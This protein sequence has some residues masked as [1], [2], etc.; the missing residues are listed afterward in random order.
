M[1]SSCD[2]ANETRNKRRRKCIVFLPCRQK[3]TVIRIY[4]DEVQDRTMRKPVMHRGQDR[5]PPRIFQCDDGDVEVRQV[6]YE[7]RTM[8]MQSS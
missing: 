6:G 4:Q 2:T 8:I 7:D 1:L 3:R 5:Q